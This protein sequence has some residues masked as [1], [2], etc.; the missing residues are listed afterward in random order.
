MTHWTRQRAVYTT[1]RVRRL[2]CLSLN[3]MTFT[4]RC[5]EP[6]V[7]RH[8]VPELSCFPSVTLP[9]PCGDWLGC[10]RRSRRPG[11]R[12]LMRW[13][14]TCHTRARAPRSSHLGRPRWP[15]MRPPENYR[16]SGWFVMRTWRCCSPRPLPCIGAGSRDAA[17]MRTCTN[18]TRPLRAGCSAPRSVRRT[19]CWTRA[20]GRCTRWWPS[21][22]RWRRTVTPAP[23]AGHTRPWSR[24][25]TIRCS[26]ATCS[27][28]PPCSRCTGAIV[29]SMNGCV[30]AA[31][32]CAAT[33]VT[34][35]CAPSATP[36]CRRRLS[37]GRTTSPS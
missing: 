1:H 22:C 10:Q 18:S 7:F 3:T 8:A 36:N 26:Q 13:P 17:N 23:L 27:S 2:N 9:A 11:C 14:F 35:A 33:A 28:P 5:R 19:A 15:R 21:R 25:A 24:G 4:K 29:S 6:T 12:P 20:S 34:R 16:R 31:R 30:P 37:S 32:P